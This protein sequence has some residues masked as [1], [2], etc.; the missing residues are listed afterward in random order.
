M[1]RKADPTSGKT[2][3]G[4]RAAAFGADVG[5]SLAKLAIREAGGWKSDTLTEDL[6][7]SY[8]A[9]MKGWRFAYLDDVIVPAEIPETVSALEVQQRRW[10]QGGVQT[11]RKILPE[12]LRGLAVERRPLL[13]EHPAGAR[14]G[15]GAAED[16]RLDAGGA[17]PETATQ[18]VHGA[19]HA[20]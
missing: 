15:A 4:P 19:A 12:L 20:G 5:A 9:Q 10:A 6:D 2:G 18:D 7:L 1:I 14:G 8:R 3:D 16:Q 11:G 13:V 17:V